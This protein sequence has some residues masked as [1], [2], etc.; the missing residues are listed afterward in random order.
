MKENAKPTSFSVSWKWRMHMWV[1]AFHY[2][3]VHLPPSP[4]PSRLSLGNSLTPCSFFLL[5]LAPTNTPEFCTPPPLT[6]ASMKLVATYG[7]SSHQHRSAPPG[8]PSKNNLLTS[9]ALLSLLLPSHCGKKKKK[10]A[11]P[12]ESVWC[13][14]K[15]SQGSSPSWIT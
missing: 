12:A 3:A 13:F 14:S 6:A 5:S 9:V 1:R 8:R 15:T 10:K 7:R 4:T 2:C 11:L